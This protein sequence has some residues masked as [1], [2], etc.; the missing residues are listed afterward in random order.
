MR[1]REREGKKEKAGQH[2][3]T[4]QQQQEQQTGSLFLS[5]SSRINSASF[6]CLCR[7]QLSSSD[8]C[9]HSPPLL[10][11]FTSPHSLSRSR[12]RSHSHPSLL[13]CLLS[14]STF[15][16]SSGCRSSALRSVR[17]ESVE[18]P[19]VSQRRVGLRVQLRCLFENE[20]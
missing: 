13:C 17:I 18:S 19:Q 8:C 11:H 5:N 9:R 2:R 1:Q 12:S 14:S 20:S 3:T 7:V 16:L 4:A 6:T 10:F 15:K